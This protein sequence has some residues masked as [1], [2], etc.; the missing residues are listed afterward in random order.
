MNTGDTAADGRRPTTVRVWIGRVMSALVVAFLLLVSG[1]P[2]LFLPSIA[3]ESM[4]RFGWDPKQLLTIA[5]IEVAGALLYAFPRTAVLGAVLLTGLLGGAVAT[6]LR[7]DDPLLSH[8]L[9]P[10]WLGLLM[11]GGLWLRCEPLRK[12]MPLLPRDRAG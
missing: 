8:T 7:I 4:E 9:F 6:H 11:W 1:F 10:V 12:L 2:K 3:E 5:V